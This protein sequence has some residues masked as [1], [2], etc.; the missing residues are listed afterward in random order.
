[1]SFTAD[2]LLSLTPGTTPYSDAL[3]RY[4][5]AMRG[6][7]IDALLA[8]TSLA[9]ELA[10]ARG[11]DPSPE[12]D[13]IHEVF[14][15]YHKT[16]YQSGAH[17]NFPF[18]CAVHA[19]YRNLRDVHADM[20]E[21]AHRCLEHELGNGLHHLQYAV[22]AGMA[23]ATPLLRELK[24]LHEW[25]QLQHVARHF[26][27]DAGDPDLVADFSVIWRALR[28][29]NSAD[30]RSEAQR[31]VVKWS[32]RDDITLMEKLAM[33]LSRTLN[34]LVLTSSAGVLLTQV[35][36]LLIEHADFERAAVAMRVLHRY[37]AAGVWGEL[38]SYA[39][40]LAE[41]HPVDDMVN[42]LGRDDGNS[43]ETWA[44]LLHEYAL[45]GHT[46][47]ADGAA[48]EFLR[49][50]RDSGHPLGVLPARLLPCETGLLDLVYERPAPPDDVVP[51]T[52][53]SFG[54]SRADAGVGDRRALTSALRSLRTSALGWGNAKV[55]AETYAFSEAQSVTAVH[56]DSLSTLPFEPFQRD[57]LVV[58][59]IGLP[60]VYRELF[61]SAARGG[62][63]DGGQRN[64][65]GR[66]AMWQ[67]VAALAG[68]PMTSIDDVSEAARACTWW[69]FT[70]DWF[71]RMYSMGYLA[72][73]PDGGSMAV[74]AVDDY[75]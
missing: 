72:M 62:I 41:H 13:V 16:A 8:L 63:Y 60:T 51:N 45:R 61:G 3:Q 21:A 9:T 22:D 7:D 4:L 40:L 66:L 12:D 44:V 27:I 18:G 65:Y 20:S 46:Y 32:A 52:A 59:Q 75:D 17:V 25:H 5:L 58:S 67:S 74:L 6:G 39:T 69:S 26:W 42:L 37:E 10:F 53:I 71:Y 30:D 28:E 70:S 24:D 57:N 43:G 73:R 47:R 56:P 34:S 19:K 36:H 33:H 48:T 14:D 54:P 64:A 15:R 50:L 23:P 68:V 49:T 38:R 29:N 1:M 2:H 35:M 11:D 31:V 55:M